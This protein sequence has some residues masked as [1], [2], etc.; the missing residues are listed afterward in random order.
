MNRIDISKNKIGDEA[1]QVFF[2][3]LRGT[4][5]QTLAIANVE[6]GLVSLVIFANVISDI[7]NIPT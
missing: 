3:A 5:I 7:D 4:Q 6:I 1:A 2:E